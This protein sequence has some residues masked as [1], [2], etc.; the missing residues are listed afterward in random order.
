MITYNNVKIC[1]IT[2]CVFKLHRVN[3]YTS[4]LQQCKC[5]LSFIIFILITINLSRV[6]AVAIFVVIFHV[7]INFSWM[8]NTNEN[9]G[10]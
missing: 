4:F 3:C 7:A 9:L 1:P 2:G 6:I 5:N 10:L 8:K